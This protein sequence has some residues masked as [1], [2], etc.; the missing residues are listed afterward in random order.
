MHLRSEN[1][2]STYRRDIVIIF[3]W[4]C[5]LISTVGCYDTSGQSFTKTRTAQCTRTW[6][7]GLVHSSC[8]CYSTS[9]D[10]CIHN[11]KNRWLWSNNQSCLLWLQGLWFGPTRVTIRERGYILI[12][13]RH[14]GTETKTNGRTRLHQGL[15]NPQLD[16]SVNDDYGNLFISFFTE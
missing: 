3:S 15:I 5:T 11:K 9:W 12:K 8:M 1:S 16:K 2:R 14:C 13:P 4:L 10:L 7:V 6:I